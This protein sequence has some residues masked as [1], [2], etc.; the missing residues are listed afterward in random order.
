M[1]RTSLLIAVVVLAIGPPSVCGAWTVA[2]D[3][4]DGDAGD[5]VDSNYING[6]SGTSL[7]SEE[8]VSG[9]QS[10]EMSITRGATGWGEWGAV[11]EYPARLSQN[12]ELWFRV[13]AYFPKGFDYDADPWLKFLRLHTLKPNGENG[14]YVDWYIDNEDRSIPYRWIYEGEQQWERFGE[15]STQIRRGRWATYEMYVR[16]G[17]TP[18]SEG[19]KA[20]VRVWKNGKLLKEIKDRI[21]LENAEMASEKALIFT[22]WNSGAPQ[23]QKMYMDD[24][25]LTTETPSAYDD[26]GNPMIGTGETALAPSAPTNVSVQ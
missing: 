13:Q 9:T 3:F 23:T 7:T 12:E 6:F 5:P 11:I 22:W 19:G 20:I 21:T 14:G 2:D 18:A 26:H 25:R 10:A 8:S 24:I 17:S 16:F 15:P 1:R 4:E